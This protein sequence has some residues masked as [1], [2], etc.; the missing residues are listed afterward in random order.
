MY[1]IIVLKV[2]LAI[3]RIFTRCGRKIRRLILIIKGYPFYEGQSEFLFEM[4]L[5]YRYLF[6]NINIC[7]DH[8]LFV[9]NWFEAACIV[10]KQLV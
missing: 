2:V 3:H 10:C 4:N 6:L 1:L 7:V 5:S 8:L 9:N